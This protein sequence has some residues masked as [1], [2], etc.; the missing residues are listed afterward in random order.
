[1]ETH[2]SEIKHPMSNRVPGA[3]EKTKDHALCKDLTKM[4]MRELLDLKHRQLRLLENKCE[5]LDK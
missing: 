4:Q 2:L 1:M 3:I 5:Q